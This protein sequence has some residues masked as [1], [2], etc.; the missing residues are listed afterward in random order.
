MKNIEEYGFQI[1]YMASGIILTWIKPAQYT[2]ASPESE[3]RIWIRYWVLLSFTVF[4]E[5]SFFPEFSGNLGYFFLRSVVFFYLSE[6]KF[7]NSD[8]NQDFSSFM[9]KKVSETRDL[10]SLTDLL[11]SEED[12]N[13]KVKLHPWAPNP[14]SLSSLAVCRI[15]QL[16]SESLSTDEQNYLSTSALE[17]IVQMTESSEDAKSINA[18]ICL[19]FLSEKQI[20]LN[21]LITLSPLSR[22]ESLIKHSSKQVS[23][24]TLRLCSNLYCKN[25]ELQ[26]EFLR[27]KYYKYLIQNFKENDPITVFETFENTFALI[28]VW[29]N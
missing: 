9:L 17:T 28:C 3:F 13:S 8:Y 2:L 6:Q 20:L 18:M 12:I 16:S 21:K 1:I 26:K 25:R 27:L 29:F 22:L 5:Q 14:T 4:L 19:L 10:K 23:Q 11:S 15:G 7:I 24:S